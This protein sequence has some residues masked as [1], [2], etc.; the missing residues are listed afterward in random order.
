MALLGVTRM[1]APMLA[2][3]G[4]IGCHPPTDA[5]EVAPYERVTRGVA[6]DERLPLIVA[7]HG[8]GASPEEI[9]H[10]VDDLE[11]PLRVI[12][13]RGTLPVHGGWAWYSLNDPLA[14]P[15]NDPALRT[16]VVHVLA[17]LHQARAK[18][19]VCGKPIV[20]GFSQGAVVTY[21]L[22]ATAPTELARALPIAGLL[23]P[24]QWPTRSAPADAAPM[25]AFHGE[26]DD[27][28]RIADDRESQSALRRQGFQVALRAYPEVSHSVS[29]DELRDIRLEIA[30][31]IRE[32]GCAR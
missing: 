20:V 9:S 7:L 21:A 1:L 28:V 8:Y 30:R 31:A 15:K 25:V 27:R 6:A 22:A 14:S 13:P 10:L 11:L 4:S 29:V 2:L 32:Q 23:P 18:R 17:T 3:F 19:R 12:A 26:A 16:A 24:S 5:A